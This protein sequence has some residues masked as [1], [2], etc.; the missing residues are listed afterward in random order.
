MIWMLRLVQIDTQP[1]YLPKYK[2]T[3]Q[4][5]QKRRKTLKN[6]KK[7]RKASENVKQNPETSKFYSCSYASPS[8]KT[9]AAAA[10]TEFR[11]VI[12]VS[13]WADYLSGVLI[14]LNF[15]GH[16]RYCL[17]PKNTKKQQFWTDVYRSRIAPILMMLYAIWS[18]WPDLSFETHFVF[19]RSTSSRRCDALNFHRP[20]L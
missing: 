12:W 15:F 7:C 10:A 16:R 14:F 17:W 13:T 11:F 5:I 18:S 2:E 3:S 8:R 9:S 4:N 19:V 20:R 6:V 1:E